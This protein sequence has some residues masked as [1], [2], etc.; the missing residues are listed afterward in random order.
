MS[1]PLAL[2]IEDEVDLAEILAKA[3]HSAGYSTEIICRG[4]LARQR[5]TEVVPEVV[6]LDLHLPWVDGSE[7]LHQI[8]GD[9]RL[10]QTRVI[11]A[12]ADHLMAD[13]LDGQAD[14]V[15]VKPISFR[16]LRDLSARLRPPASVPT[17]QPMA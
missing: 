7:L 3:L 1:E 15:L 4:D 14:V 13:G 16:Q 8:R 2:I 12:S 6:V 9:S 5:L 10:A 17:T 11:V